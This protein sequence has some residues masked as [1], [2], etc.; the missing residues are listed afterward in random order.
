MCHTSGNHN[1]I[2]LCNMMKFQTNVNEINLHFFFKNTN[3]RHVLS[4]GS[5]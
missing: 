5:L 2:A 3:I 1:P 4:I